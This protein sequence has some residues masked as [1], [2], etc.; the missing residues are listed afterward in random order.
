MEKKRLV[1]QMTHSVF[2][3]SQV[4]RRNRYNL[5]HFHHSSI[6][7]AFYDKLSY[8]SALWD[9][10]Y[11]QQLIIKSPIFLPFSTCLVRWKIQPSNI[12][13]GWNKRVIKQRH[14]AWMWWQ[15]TCMWVDP[16]CLT[17]RQTD[18]FISAILITLLSDTLLNHG[19][20]NRHKWGQI[21]TKRE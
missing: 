1:S 21:D 11:W 17:V 16:L 13:I 20:Q 18:T 10:I 19:C 4:Y 14:L 15:P 7:Q 3:P 2:Y 9:N 12:V 8:I 5:V 6:T